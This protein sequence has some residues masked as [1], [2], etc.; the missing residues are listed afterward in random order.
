MD[1]GMIPRNDMENAILWSI[2]DLFQNI[3]TINATF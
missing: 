2:Y 1:R 3:Y